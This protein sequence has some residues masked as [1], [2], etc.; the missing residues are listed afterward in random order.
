MTRHARRAA[1]WCAGSRMARQRPRGSPSRPPGHSAGC[2]RHRPVMIFGTT[3]AQLAAYVCPEPHTAA[4]TM[5]GSGKIVTSMRARPDHPSHCLHRPAQSHPRRPHHRH[6]RP[7]PHRQDRYY[8][9]RHPAPRRQA[10]PHRSG[11]GTRRNRHPAAHPGP[12]HPHRRRNRRTAPR[13]HPRPQPQLPAHR[14]ETENTVTQ[15]GF[16]VSSMS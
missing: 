4:H 12:A 2:N 8:R 5:T 16:T 3:S 13:A 10:P 6:P 9:H 7:G 1:G 15:R 11:K 14:P